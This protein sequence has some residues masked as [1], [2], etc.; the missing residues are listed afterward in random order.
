MTQ[1]KSHLNNP[2]LILATVVLAIVTS[3]AIWL[4]ILQSQ[5]AVNSGSAQT[6]AIGQMA[7]DFQTVSLDGDDIILSDLQGKVVLLNFWATWC[8]PCRIEMPLFERVSS[9]YGDEFVILA[10]NAEETPEQIAEFRNQFRLTFPLALDEDGTIQR[11]YNIL[12]YPTTY[13]LDREGTIAAQH[14]GT[15]SPSD[16]SAMLDDLLG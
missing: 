7:P 2:R 6:L 3:V 5:G 1:D 9:Q 4:V 11:Q 10:V 15:F 16:L 8:G 12:N 13:I 14:F